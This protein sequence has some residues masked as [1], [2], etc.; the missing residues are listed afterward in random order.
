MSGA[1]QYWPTEFGLDTKQTRDSWLF[2][3]IN[4]CSYL[5]AGLMLEI[6]FHNSNTVTY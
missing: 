1:N 4:A 2:G 6:H 5:F 3:L